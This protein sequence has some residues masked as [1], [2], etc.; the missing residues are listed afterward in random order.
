MAQNGLIKS[1][2]QLYELLYSESVIENST[3][4]FSGLYW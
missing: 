1:V 3:C 2:I 4:I